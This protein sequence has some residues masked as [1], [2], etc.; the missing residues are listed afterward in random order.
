[1]GCIIIE[2][3]IVLV[4]GWENGKLQ[5]FTR[6]RTENGT[7]NDPF[8][9][10]MPVV[11][12]WTENLE[13]D[14]GSY[15]II[16][17][18]RTARDMIHIEPEARLYSWEAYLDVYERPNSNE[19]ADARREMMDKFIQGPKAS[20]VSSKENPRA[21]QVMEKNPIREDCLAKK[22]WPSVQSTSEIGNF[23]KKFNSMPGPAD[24]RELFTLIHDGDGH[25]EKRQDL[26]RQFAEAVLTADITF[27]ETVE[28]L[29]QSRD[30]Y[31]TETM[32][33]RMNVIKVL[34]GEV[35]VNKMGFGRN[36]PLCLAL[37]METR[38]LPNSCFLKARKLTTKMI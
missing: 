15:S 38:W 14:D 2:L 20:Q 26:A 1:M 32:E 7:P 23:L 12:R 22:G 17:L 5:T 27:A 9:K 34:K 3:A 8:H 36:T 35:I 10:N 31:S 37:G 21:R 25:V 4:Y 24:I 28:F 18:M 19:T 11:T 6:K 29:Q 33:Y 16:G 30:W 13:R